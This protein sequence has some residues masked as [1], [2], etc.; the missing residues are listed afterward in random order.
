MDTT[1]TTT[2]ATI[3]SIPFAKINGVS[4]LSPAHAAGLQEGDLI[5]EFGS[6]INH[7]NH[8]Q[9]GALMPMVA[10][11]A[12]TQQAITIV[13]LRKQPTTNT[14]NLIQ[15]QLV[16]KPWPGRGLLG[17]HIVPYDTP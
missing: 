4:P 5:V 1:T 9:L 10:S 17:C 11:A 14:N 2:T 8:N 13:L 15:V 12:D 7:T 6:T 3:N 16:P